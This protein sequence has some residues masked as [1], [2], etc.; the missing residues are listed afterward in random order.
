MSF[1]TTAL[2]SLLLATASTA[3]PVAS[4]RNEQELASRAGVSGYVIYPPGGTTYDSFG[5]AESNNG[6]GGQSFLHIQYE[7]VNQETPY[8]GTIGVDIYLEDPTGVQDDQYLTYDFGNPSG[9][10]IDGYF[11]PPSGACGA[12]NLVF[13]EHQT[14]GNYGDIIKFRA[15]APSINILCLPIQ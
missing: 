11:S 6:A 8:T 5:G 4:S 1:F 3:L 2:T 10:L 14:L 12:Y 13:I 15:A 9:T 7:G